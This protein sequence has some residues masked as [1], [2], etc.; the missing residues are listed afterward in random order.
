[1]LIKTTE[2]AIKTLIYLALQDKPEPLS[3]RQIAQSLGFSPTYLAK[4]TNLLVRADI[5]KAHRGA[6]GGV[7]L[8]RSAGQISLLEIVEACQGRL[9]GDYC[10]ESAPPSVKV[11]GFHQA[12]LEVHQ[13]MVHTLSKWTLKDL[14][15]RPGPSGDTPIP[16]CRMANLCPLVEGA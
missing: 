14:A 5:L 2:L 13:A 6:L 4:T 9:V 16:G 10:Q 3:P 7:T 15:D 12:M 1:M 11:C 8:G